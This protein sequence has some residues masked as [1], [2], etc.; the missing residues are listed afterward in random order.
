MYC[1]ILRKKSKPSALITHSQ[2]EEDMCC[3]L[4]PLFSEKN[5]NANNTNIF[6]R[7]TN[8]RRKKKAAV[9][10]HGFCQ[11]LTTTGKWERRMTKA[12][13]IFAKWAWFFNFQPVFQAQEEKVTE[14]ERMR[15]GENNITAGFNILYVF[16][17]DEG[18]LVNTAYSK[19]WC[20]KFC[21]NCKTSLIIRKISHT[22]FAKLIQ[23]CNM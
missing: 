10:R 2:M 18:M 14:S 15:Q 13:M 19:G 9:I 8:E 20:I 11:K 21:W 22:F 17:G 23:N 7:R 5:C 1:L 12:G 4:F 16:S 6:I 3:F